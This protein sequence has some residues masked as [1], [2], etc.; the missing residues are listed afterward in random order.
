MTSNSIHFVSY[1]HR[2]WLFTKKLYSPT[3][4]IY[5][6]NFNPITDNRTIIEIVNDGLCAPYT[7]ASNPFLGRCLPSVLINLFEYENNTSL[8]TN[9][10]VEQINTH[11]FGINSISD[12]GRI[13]FSDLNQ[14]KESLAL[15]I[16]IECMYT[17][18]G[19]GV[20]GDKAS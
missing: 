4:Y 1:K 11:I 5:I 19:K 6:Y 20:S 15:F 3:A 13:I 2:H 7:I 10:S 17:I 18:F 14:I 8:K 12:V 9:I 16:L